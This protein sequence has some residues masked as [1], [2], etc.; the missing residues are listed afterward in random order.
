MIGIIGAMAIEVKL[1]KE[2]MTEKQEEQVSSITFVRGILQGKE[3]VV[4]QSGVGKVSAATCAQTMVLHFGVKKLLSIGVGGSLSP[5]LHIGDVII[6]SG[7]VEH[8]MDTSAVG[9]PVGW[10]SGLNL[11]ELPVDKTMAEELIA[12]CKKENLNYLYGIVASGDQ[13]ISSEEKAAWIRKT[14]NA[15]SS[16]MEAA[17]IAHVAYM[18]QC[19][20]ASFRVASDE[21]NGKSPTDY[22]AFKVKA[23]A[24]SSAIVLQW[25]AYL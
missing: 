25:L 23:A 11:I 21:A 12:I 7:C 1:L 8:D 5:E 15:V 6:A 14:F 18:N 22:E 16:E 10:I 4:A 3:V 17:A 20:F 19:P 13:F 24:T 9:D 2:R